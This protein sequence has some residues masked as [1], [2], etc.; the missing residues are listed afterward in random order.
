MSFIFRPKLL[1]SFQNYTSKDLWHDVSAGLTIGIV[2]LP[3]AMA[4][5][6]AS[7]LKPETGIYT[8]IV[9]GFLISLLGGSKVQ[10][11]GPAGAYIIIVYGIVARYGV[12]G[13]VIATI[14]AGILLFLMGLLRWGALIRYVPVAI[15]TGFT[16]G[17][18][19]LIALSQVKDVLGLQIQALPSDFFP[20]TIVIASHLQTISMPTAIIS[21]ACLC[22]LFGWPMLVSKTHL[23]ILTYI[24]G[25]MIVLIGGTT[26]SVALDLPIA[27]LGTEFGG[28]PSVLPK[29]SVPH[30]DLDTMTHL[31]R[32]A[33]TIAL[34][35]AIESLLCARVADD[36]IGEQH[37]PNQELMAQGIANVVAPMLG[38]YCATGTIA[39]TVTNVR[40]GARTP[41]AGIVHALTL[42]VI[43]LIAAPLAK[44]IPLA[45]LGAILIYVAYRM[46]EWHAFVR[47]WRYSNFYRLIFL[48]T[49][50]LTVVADLSVALEVGL[51]LSFLFF[52]ARVKSLTRLE[53]VGEVEY[54]NERMLGREIEMYHVYGSLFFG[55]VNILEE[56]M[57]PHKSAPKILVL[58]L[59]NLLNLDTSGVEALGKL[60]AYMRGQGKYLLIAGANAQV[61]SLFKRSHFFDAAGADK[62]YETPQDALSY[63]KGLIGSL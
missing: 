59:V 8:A 10:I 30:I 2:A 6:I 27:T 16:N 23:R 1:S 40:M 3:L 29:I 41:L 46:G 12:H 17:I 49:F 35:G 57:M 37:D 50:V 25:S 24:P 60:Q 4:F 21:I 53:P 48:S 42:L 9:A 33:I 14:L 47:L 61:M 18:A 32:P 51:A 39:R 34:L 38:G 44:S 54:P 19:V 5:A 26:L 7:G 45:V 56:L 55:T 58:S 20:K 11:G 43:L 13:L 52:I 15:V 31:V 36:I 62:F 22:V 28:I 63:A